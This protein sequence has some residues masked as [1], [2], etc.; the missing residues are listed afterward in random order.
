LTYGS[1]DMEKSYTMILT[2]AFLKVLAFW[3][4]I[5]SLPDMLYI[6]KYATH[7]SYP[8]NETSLQ[9]DNQITQI[10]F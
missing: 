2:K 7:D 4:F 9:L 1:R 5:C 8:I 6:L 10:S 3:P